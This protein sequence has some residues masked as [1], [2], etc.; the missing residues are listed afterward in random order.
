V[1]KII[2]IKLGALGDV[3]RTTCILEGLHRKYRAASIS[4]LTAKSALCLLENNPLIDNIFA[5]E[6]FVSAELL[7]KSYDLVISLD[8]EATAC[9]L[10]A[11][12]TTRKFFGAYRLNDKTLYTGDSAD[13]FD[14]S[15]ISV[16]GKVE[17]DKRKKENQRSYPDILFYALGI[18]EGKPSLQLDPRNREFARQ[19]A[20]IHLSPAKLKIGL[21]TGAG[22]R[23]QFKQLSIP[24]T[25]D[26]AEY[27]SLDPDREILLFGG[28][29]ELQRN[30]RIIS[31]ANCSI[32][33]TG[34]SNSI[35]DFAALIGLCDLLITSDSLAFHIA[36]AIDVTTIVF[37][38]PTSSAEIRLFSSGNKV[39][40]PLPC[41]C[42]YKKRCDF[43]PNCMDVIPTGEILQIAEEL[44]ST[45]KKRSE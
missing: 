8:D 22:D 32:I 18:T 31:N 7:R 13:W 24:Q 26:I 42:C 21:N 36:S 23:W 14:M 6:D 15:L 12:L 4:W 16:F 33:E 29:A 40:S 19:F 3:L 28:P 20:R 9:N 25:I 2:I 27:F 17:A 10:A 35:N 1:T 38:G 11:H 41:V 5:I 37:F 45:N 30:E 43:K 34:T 44:L 39:I